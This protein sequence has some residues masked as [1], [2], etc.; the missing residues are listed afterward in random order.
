MIIISKMSIDKVNFYDVS[1]NLDLINRIVS[2]NVDFNDAQTMLDISNLAKLYFSDEVDEKLKLIYLKSDKGI[3]YTCFNG[4]FGMNIEDKLSI[5]SNSIDMIIENGMLDTINDKINSLKVKFSFNRRCVVGS[6]FKDLDFYYTSDKKINV[7]SSLFVDKI[8]IDISVDSKKM[9]GYDKLSQI[10]YTLAEMIFLIVGDMPCTEETIGRLDN[11]DINYYFDI[12]D[13]YKNLG[14]NKKSIVL[15][16]IDSSTLNKNNMKKFELF[17]RNTKI[18]YDLFLR[19]VNCDDYTEIKN[20]NLIQI[21]EGLYKT[22]QN[23]Y[24]IELR[25]LLDAYFNSSVS[26]KK[27]L[28]RR[29]KRKIA[30]DNQTPIFIYKSVNHRNYL[31][32][33]EHNQ[34][35]NVF[36]KTENIYAYYKLVLSLRV[37]LLEYIGIGFDEYSLIDAVN[38]IE[39]LA[40]ILKIRFSLRLN[41]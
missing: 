32:H 31:S 28:S 23:N 7:T 25:L 12:V 21:I 15:N 30:H 2:L 24:K 29:D 11:I 40:K 22:I 20:C 36:F 6:V 10:I 1:G 9:C 34:V 39:S 17:R 5:V 14:K 38:K 8:Y 35:K 41:K 13:K 18:I 37:F 4:I 33:L 27:I 19:V 16:V 26:M 3:D